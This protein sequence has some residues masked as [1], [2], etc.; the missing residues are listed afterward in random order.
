MR[1]PTAT[2]ATVLAAILVLMGGSACDRNGEDPEPAG[3]A[4]TPTAEEPSADET[5]EETGA[6]A[7]AGEEA[8]GEARESERETPAGDPFPELSAQT[9][10]G[11]TVDLA[12]DGEATLV[13]LWA[14]WCAPCIAEF[15][16]F[17]K[18]G[19]TWGDKGLRLVGLSIEGEEAKD[20]LAT[21]VDEH[22]MPFD[23]V[24]FGP[25]KEPLE[26]F[27]G[28][29]VPATFLYD[30]DGNL[31]W[32]HGSMVETPEIEQLEASLEKLLGSA[33]N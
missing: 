23:Q 33:P 2:F 7:E 9:L 18:L 22:E 32:W 4:E 31:V 21:F 26:V 1:R 15:P 14:T 29:S 10:D 3:E 28:G 6:A 11:E 30:A 24:L 8:T 19:E 27:G 20:R 12:P 25:D 5:A 17:R 16:E 13:N